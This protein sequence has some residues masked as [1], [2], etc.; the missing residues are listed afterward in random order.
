MG[1]HFWCPFDGAL[2]G[3]QGLESLY[4]LSFLRILLQGM[5]VFMRTSG[6]LACPTETVKSL[7]PN[8]HEAVE[9]WM[10]AKDQGMDRLGTKAHSVCCTHLCTSLT[11]QPQEAC[12][13]LQASECP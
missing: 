10:G 13:Y 7:K 1:V 4:R 11:L 5:A 9:G 2:Q 3:G 8:A 12:G 6:A